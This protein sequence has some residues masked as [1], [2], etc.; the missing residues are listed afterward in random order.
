MKGGQQL[1]GRRAAVFSVRLTPEQADYIE[2][3]AAASEEA[4]GRPP[5]SIGEFMRDAALARADDVFRLVVPARA[6]NS[7]AYYQRPARNGRRP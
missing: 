5:K 4:K 7:A 3:A 1:N 2:R 6:R